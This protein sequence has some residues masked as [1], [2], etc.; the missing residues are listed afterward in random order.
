MTLLLQ[1]VSSSFRPIVVGSGD[2]LIALT[3][4]RGLLP[5]GLRPVGLVYALRRRPLGHD[6]ASGGPQA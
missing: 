3:L 4:F 1:P 2:Q 6:E 5:L